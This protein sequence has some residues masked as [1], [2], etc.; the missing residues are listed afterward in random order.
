VKKEAIGGLFGP[1]PVPVRRGAALY[2]TRLGSEGCCGYH[3][4]VSVLRECTSVAGEEPQIER[5]RQASS[6][7]GKVPFCCGVL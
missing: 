7:A 6:C 4:N 5:D 3:G 1:N 2:E